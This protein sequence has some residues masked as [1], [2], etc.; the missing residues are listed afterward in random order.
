MIE[1][2]GPPSSFASPACLPAP[3]ITQ[4]A[5]APRV[6]EA[7]SKEDRGDDG[8]HASRLFQ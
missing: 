5:A 2:T 6:K 1:G 4:G 7:S 3:S 8:T